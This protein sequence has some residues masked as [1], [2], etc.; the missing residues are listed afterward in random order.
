VTGEAQL[1][2][3]PCVKVLGLRK[4]AEALSSTV[5][6]RADDFGAVYEENYGLL[7]GTAVE[8]FHISEIDAQTLAHEVFL[9]YFLKAH[10]VMNSRAWL[11]SAICN[12]SKY[13]LR[14][15]ARYVPFFREIEDVIDP[16]H[17]RADQ[18]L[19][20]QIAAREAFSCVTARCQLALRLRYLEGYSTPEIAAELN[21]SAK[22]AEKLVRR[23]LRQA[24]CRYTKK[25][26]G[27]DRA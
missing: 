11:I 6:E 9:A 12:A 19:P 17:A 1:L 18:T 21:T 5:L 16:Q 27:D 24:Q 15:R 8:H 13:Y 4:T 7:V 10:E 3:S 22:Y 14:L 2:P 23:C 20:D 25:G 26:D